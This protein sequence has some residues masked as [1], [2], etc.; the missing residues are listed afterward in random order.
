MDIPQMLERLYSL[1]Y[2]Q[3]QIANAVGTTHA[4]VQRWGKGASPSYAMGCRLEMLIK[5]SVDIRKSPPIH[6][7]TY[8]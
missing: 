3:R 8:Q 4:S 7:R 2:S 6:Q 5:A 1:G